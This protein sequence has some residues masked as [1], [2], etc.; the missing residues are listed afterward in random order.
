LK[1]SAGVTD[2]A[3]W[4]AALINKTPCKGTSVLG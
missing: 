2:A 1:V 4:C 3:Y